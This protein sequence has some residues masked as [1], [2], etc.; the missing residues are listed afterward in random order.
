MG[1][2]GVVPEGHLVGDRLGNVVQVRARTMGVDV[3][4]VLLRIEAGFLQRERDGA[5]LG[6]TVRTRCGGVVGVAGVAVA[7]HL[8]VDLGAARQGVVQGLEDEDGGAV[9]HHEALPVRVERKGGVLGVGGPGKGLR[10]GETGHADRNRGV[11]GAAGDNRVGIA[12]AEKSF[13]KIS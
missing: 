10:I 9:A 6:G 8:A 11:F 1:L 4:I 2:V 3:Q 13:V 7:H 12:V 5:G